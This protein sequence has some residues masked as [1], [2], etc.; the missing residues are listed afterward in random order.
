MR[1]CLRPNGKY[2][3][4]YYRLHLFILSFFPALFIKP[5]SSFVACRNARLHFYIHIKSCP[6]PPSCIFNHF[7]IAPMSGGDFNKC[8]S[9]QRPKHAAGLTT[10]HLV[11]FYSLSKAFRLRRPCIPGIKELNKYGRMIQNCPGICNI[12]A[13]IRSVQVKPSI[14]EKEKATEV[15]A[16]LQPWTAVGHTEQTWFNDSPWSQMAKCRTGV[17][18]P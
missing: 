9:I 10:L 11:D 16:V 2:S 4:V 6:P 8:Y 14:T 12:L 18:R 7:Q 1:N 5:S 3:S 15:F 13:Y 17:Q